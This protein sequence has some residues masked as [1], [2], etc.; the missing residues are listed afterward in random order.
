MTR[1]YRLIIFF[2]FHFLLAIA[3]PLSAESINGKVIKVVDGDTIIVLDDNG[4]KYRIRLAA[5]D[6]PEKKS[7]P[8]SSESTMSLRW[9]V[10]NKGATVE[11]SKYDRYGRIVGKIMVGSKGDKH[12]LIIECARTTDVGLEQIKSGMAWHYKR[13]QNEQSIEDRKFYSSAERVAKKK[14]IGLWRD[15]NPIQPWKWRRDNRLKALRKAFQMKGSKKKKY[16]Q[17]IGVDPDQLKIFIDEAVKNEDEAIKQK[18]EQSG[19]DEE[20]FAIEFKVS[21]E[22]LKAIL[23]PK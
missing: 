21:P 12:C 3:P 6:A 1:D 11:Y 22:R 17:E 9:L 14:Q 20:E 18:F 7:Q 23:N 13:Y 15:K 4:F 2:W 16:A 8:Y 10:H 5:I 19:L